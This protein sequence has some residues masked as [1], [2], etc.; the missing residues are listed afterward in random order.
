MPSSKSKA[1]PL[2]GQL[3]VARGYCAT[4]DVDRALKIQREQDLRGE[5]HRL[6]GII[7]ISEG[8]LSTTQLI[9]MLKDYEKKPAGRRA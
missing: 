5:K 1:R 6:I 9:E 7:L 8:I 3:A 2:F 4:K